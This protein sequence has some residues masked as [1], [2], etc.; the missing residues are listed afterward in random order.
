MPP[1]PYIPGRWPPCGGGKAGDEAIRDTLF[2]DRPHG[3]DAHELA[4]AL[5]QSPGSL[6][7]FG[8]TDPSPKPTETLQSAIDLKPTATAA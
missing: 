7:T 8:A 3:L 5:Q 2:R 1:P 6:G 4:N